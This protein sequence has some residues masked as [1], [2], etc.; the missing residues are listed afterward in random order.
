MRSNRSQSAGA[1]KA[2]APKAADQKEAPPS[3]TLND[4]IGI[5]QGQLTVIKQSAKSKK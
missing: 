1:D 4:K 2:L 3:L 5:A